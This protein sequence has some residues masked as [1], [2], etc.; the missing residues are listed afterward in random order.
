MATQQNILIRKFGDMAIIITVGSW[1]DYKELE[2]RSTHSD[3]D[4]LVTGIVTKS[5]YTNMLPS[6]VIN[7]DNARDITEGTK[8]MG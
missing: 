5:I 7:T 2:M 4:M 8:G 3:P 6:M 1:D